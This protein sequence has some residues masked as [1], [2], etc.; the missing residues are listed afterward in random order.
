VTYR[1]WYR[2]FGAKHR[3]ILEK[4]KGMERE[5]IVDYFRYENMRERHPDFCP[6][7]AEGTKCHDLEDLNCYLCGCPHFRYCDEGIDLSG[8]KV[9]YSLCAIGAREGRK[10]ETETAIHQDCSGCPLP[11]LRGFI[12][13]HFDRDWGRIMETCEACPK[14]RGEEEIC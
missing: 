8:D 13:R 11:H 3:E 10:I 2:E 7:Y 9:R 5:A 4:L 1:E 14:G 6:L 12:L